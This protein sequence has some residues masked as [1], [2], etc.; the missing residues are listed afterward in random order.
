MDISELINIE[1][2]D[3][4]CF[5]NNIE[6]ITL[7]KLDVEGH[8]LF[9]L[10]GAKKMIAANKIDHIQF[11]FG[12][13]NIDSQTFLKDIFIFLS[14]KYKIFRVLKDGLREIEKY[15][16]RHEIFIY[17]NFFAIAK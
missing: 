16:E 4:F 2:I 15:H 17:S 6:K 11:E 10:H 13:C 12:G 9:T 1:T 8:E 5:E 7:L 14:E 3:E